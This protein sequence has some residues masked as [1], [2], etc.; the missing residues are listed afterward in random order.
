MA[1]SVKAGIE[2]NLGNAEAALRAAEA[3]EVISRNRQA[4]NRGEAAAAWA[5]ARLHDRKTGIS[6]LGQV[7]ERRNRGKIER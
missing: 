4:E 5:R 3:L 1:Y 6:E 7:I 2:M